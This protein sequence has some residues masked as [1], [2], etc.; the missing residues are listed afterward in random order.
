MNNEQTHI[1]IVD[2]EPKICQFLEMLLRREGYSAASV[3]N[4]SDAL[5]YIERETCDLVITDLMMPGMGGLQLIE[6]L[7]RQSPSVG[8]I[9]MSVLGF[10]AFPRAR[11][12]GASYTFEKPF[13]VSEVLSAVHGL[14]GTAPSAPGP[15]ASKPGRSGAT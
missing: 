6:T 13:K 12:L 9:A 5:N 1:L 15:S 8:V 14:V 3:Y 2:D 11:D 4:A 10:D 7:R